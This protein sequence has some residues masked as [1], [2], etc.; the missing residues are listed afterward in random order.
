MVPSKS[1]TALSTAQNVPAGTPAVSTSVL[2]ATSYFSFGVAGTVT[3]GTGIAGLTQVQLQG[4]GDNTAW[5][6][7]EAVGTLPGNG[8]V[9]PFSFNQIAE[10]WSYYRLNY[11]GNTS[12]AVTVSAVIA[13]CTGFA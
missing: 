8:T 13:Y 3:N 11:T 9:T 6:L 2:T 1:V 7:I 5:V 10:G 12:A 4:S